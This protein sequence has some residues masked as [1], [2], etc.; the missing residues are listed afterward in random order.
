MERGDG[1]RLVADEK[2]PARKLW[3]APVLNQVEVAGNTYGPT[4]NQTDDPGGLSSPS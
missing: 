2:L 4:I 1:N 3:N